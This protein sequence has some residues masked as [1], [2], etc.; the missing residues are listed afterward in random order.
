MRRK[1]KLP[2]GDLVQVA[3][4]DRWYWEYYD[5]ARGR[6]LRVS[7]RTSDRG[8]AGRIAQGWAIEYLAQRD[9]YLRKPDSSGVSLGYAFRNYY[10][11]YCLDR[12]AP[13]YSSMIALYYDKYIE[14]MF[15]S[16]TILK[17]IGAAE[18]SKF[19]NRLVSEGLGAGTANKILSVLSKIFKWSAQ[20]GWIEAVPY[21]ARM[22]MQR[23]DYGYELSDREIE[24][25][26][27]AAQQSPAHVL[28]WV[29]LC[30][31]CGLRHRE[32]TSARWEDI[33]FDK[34]LIYLSSQKNRSA[35][36]APLGRARAYLE[37]VPPAQRRGPVV[38]YEDTLSNGR[39]RSVTSVYRAWR[40]LR[41][42]AGLPDFVR[43]HDLRHTF[44]SRVFRLLGYDARYLS[45]H[46]SNEA[47]LKYLHAEREGLYAKAAEAFQ[48]VV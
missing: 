35:M 19:G 37:E 1:S 42:R 13:T 47:F 18:I 27:E 2:W 46:T 34:G 31:F 8:E 6:N 25:L 3:G 22:P 45:R 44:V 32:A 14:P 36:P 33:D 21:I 41:R 20:N 11:N 39:V 12:L 10:K 4:S 38:A 5:R 40:T 28:R 23:R 26:L 29:A 15:G 48:E 16:E 7:T 9:G 17:M 24:A 30:L 43:P